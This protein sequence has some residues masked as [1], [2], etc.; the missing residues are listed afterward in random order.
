MRT[1]SPTLHLGYL[2]GTDEQP[3][4]TNLIAGLK[5]GKGKFFEKFA[6]IIKKT[7]THLLAVY[8]EIAPEDDAPADRTL[9]S[10]H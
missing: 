3:S 10:Q 2:P 4:P 1:N 5:E 8:F 6:K 7:G 9:R